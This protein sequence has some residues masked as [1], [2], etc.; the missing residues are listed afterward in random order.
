MN[1]V[2][3]S[4]KRQITLSKHE[5]A[6]INLGVAGKLMKY[7]Q[8]GRIILEPSR[9]SIVDQ[10]AGSLSEYI[11]PSLKGKSFDEIMRTTKQRV[12][13]KLARNFA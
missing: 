4:S 8:N 3:I 11:K 7:V 5:L 2:T 6:L 12:A 9:T 10:V 1:I 13:K